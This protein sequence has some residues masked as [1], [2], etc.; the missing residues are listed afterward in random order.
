[1]R[2]DEKST[3]GRTISCFDIAYFLV[4]LPILRGIACDMCVCMG[5]GMLRGVLRVSVI[6]LTFSKHDLLAMFTLKPHMRL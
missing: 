3:P 5:E 6:G 2:N 1:M 4:Q